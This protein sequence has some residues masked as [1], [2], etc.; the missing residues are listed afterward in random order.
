MAEAAE[1]TQPIDEPRRPTLRVGIAGLGRAVFNGH[2]PALKALPELYSVVAVCDLLKE[3]RDLV[4]K[5]FPNVRTYRRVED[6][7][8]DPDIDLVD[9]ALPSAEHMR[10]AMSSLQRDKW[11]LVEAPI[12]VSQDDAKILQAAAVKTRGKLVAY[13]PGLFSPDFRLAQSLVEDA[14]L[15]D[16]FEVRVRHQDYVRRD[17][18]QSVKRCL[19]GCVWHSGTDA[20]LQA[21][22]LMRTRPAQ[23]WS[24]LKRLVSLG[25]AED[26]AHIVLKA[27]TDISAGVEICGGQLAPFEPSFVIRG[28]RGSFSVMPGASEGVMR[29][30]DPAFRFPRRR[31]SVRTP[32]LDDMHENFPIVD[33][34]CALPPD[35]DKGPTAF[36][37][38]LYATI[39]T[40][41]PFPVALDDVLET[42]RYLQ[43]VKKAS[44]FAT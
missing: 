10:V 11:T 34:P 42:V 6:M 8:D 35:A 32:P 28:T 4:E 27:R 14:R 33:I 5:D 36:W 18:W 20:V 21:L 39:R 15:G 44:P 31:S 1:E 22:A 38:A 13:T 40:A 17:D 23:L 2:L 12:A 25:D 26:F 16:V 41:A 7:L 43:I 30:V 29:V 9:V 19:G 24:E 3:R 37:R